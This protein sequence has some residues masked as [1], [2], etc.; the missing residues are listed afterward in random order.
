MS[1]EVLEAGINAGTEKEYTFTWPEKMNSATD[2]DSVSLSAIDLATG[3]GVDI[4]EDRGFSGYEN[5]VFIK[6]IVAGKNYRL[7][8]AVVFG[9]ETLV[10]YFFITGL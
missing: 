7:R 5:A 4:F 10:E 1:N 2:I 8:L 3:S 6:N 9:D